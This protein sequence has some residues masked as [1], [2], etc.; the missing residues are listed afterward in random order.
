MKIRGERECTECGTR[1][2]YFE[3]GS[4][5]CPGCGS[6]RSVG[7]NDP[8]VHTDVPAPFDLTPVRAEIDDCSIE[9]LADR[10]GDHCR[11]FVRQRG[12]ITGGELRDLDDRYLAANELRHVA[13]LLTQS[14]SPTD[15]QRRYFL[16]MLE[17]ADDGERPEPDELPASLWSARGLAVADAVLDYRR[18][19]AR[20]ADDRTLAGEARGTLAAL[21]DHATRIRLLEGDVDPEIAE[22]LLTATR[23]LAS[24]IREDDELALARA[25]DRLSRLA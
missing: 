3:T 12:F 22:S 23:E 5:D 11:S 20:W 21:E 16:A 6:L 1:W 25:S 8:R 9:E 14:R 18:E 2:S 10:A 19:L 24:A 15:S 7:Q 17:G 13:H 4:V